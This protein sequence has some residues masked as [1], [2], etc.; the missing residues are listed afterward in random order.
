MPTTLEQPKQADIQSKI[1]REIEDAQK[2][3]ASAKPIQSKEDF[4]DRFKGAPQPDGGNR[5]PEQI[6]KKEQPDKP[7]SYVKGL[8][9]KKREAEEQRGALEKEKNELSEKLQQAEE[10]LKGAKTEDDIKAILADRDKAMEESRQEMELIISERDRLRQKASIFDM[11][12]DPMFVQ[13]YVE[14]L[15]RRSQEIMELIGD[16]TLKMDMMTQV[17]SLNQGALNAKTPEDKRRFTKQRQEVIFR[18]SEEMPDYERE[19]FKTK[20]TDLIRASEKHHDAMVNHQQTASQ[21]K[22]RDQQIA[23]EARRQ[24]E[25]TWGGAFESVNAPIEEES[26]I[27]EDLMQV[28]TTNSIAYDTS[29]DERIAKSTLSDGGSEFQPT[30]IARVLK[31]GAVYNRNKAMIAGLR[32]IMEE[33]S[34]TIAE[35]RGTSTSGG[36]QTSGSDTAKDAKQDRNAFFEK[37][38]GPKK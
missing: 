16:D 7:K 31:Q 10:R 37:F 2:I 1:Q 34:A 30:D 4:L 29:I 14:P 36:R 15:Q 21:F 3:A 13:N 32:K 20:I 24:T 8:E 27:S 25:A 12:E 33:Q 28:L 23:A 5:T 26:K 9:E 22:V 6:E 18:M 38:A 19:D 11:T 17:A 35:L